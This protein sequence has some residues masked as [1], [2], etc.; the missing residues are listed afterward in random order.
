MLETDLGARGGGVSRRFDV[1]LERRGAL[2]LLKRRQEPQLGTCTRSGAA[3]ASSL[4]SLPGIQ[5][6]WAGKCGGE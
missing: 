1:D 3:R 2:P 4:H 5:T 6:G